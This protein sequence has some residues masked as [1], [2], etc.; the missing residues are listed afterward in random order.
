MRE[1]KPRLTMAAAY[2]IRERNYLYECKLPGQ[3]EPRLE[4]AVNVDFVPFIR[5]VRVLCKPRLIFSRING[6]N[7]FSQS[8]LVTRGELFF[9]ATY[10]IDLLPSVSRPLLNDEDPLR[11]ELCQ[12]RHK[13]I[14]L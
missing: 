10:H 7:D 4:K 8:N 14:K 5:G 13:R 1:N 12:T 6:P 2:I 3:D 11:A 9:P